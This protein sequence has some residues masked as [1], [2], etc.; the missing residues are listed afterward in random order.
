MQV[1]S[2]QVCYL[3]IAPK[4]SGASPAKYI[5]YFSIINIIA[6]LLIPYPLPQQSYYTQEENIH[7]NLKFYSLKQR[8]V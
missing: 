2:K 7:I 8:Y 6:Y 4:N 5:C 3:Q 1:A